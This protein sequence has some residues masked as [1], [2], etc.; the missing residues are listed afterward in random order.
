MEDFIGYVTDVSEIILKKMVAEEER[1]GFPL[2]VE[3]SEYV[4]GQLVVTF[5]PRIPR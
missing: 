1:V 4:D 3:S 5:R 2:E